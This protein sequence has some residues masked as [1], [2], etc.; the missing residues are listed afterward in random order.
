MITWTNNSTGDDNR[1]SIGETARWYTTGEL[2]DW[3]SDDLSDVK[4]VFVFSQQPELTSQ[5]ETTTGSGSVSYDND[6]NTLT[7]SEAINTNWNNWT[8][9]IQQPGGTGVLR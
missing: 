7:I 9:Q 8:V 2:P 5:G 4:P 6:T 1:W 3:V